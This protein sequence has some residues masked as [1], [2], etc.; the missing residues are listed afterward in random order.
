MRAAD[1]GDVEA[2]RLLIPL[3]K[4]IKDKYGNTAFVHARKSKHADVA[5]ILRDHEAPLSASFVRAA[6]AEGIEEA[7][8]HLSDEDMAEFSD[9]FNNDLHLGG[10]GHAPP[11][12]VR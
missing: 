10:L 5:R 6:A 9:I 11:P 7:G 1:R 3:Q 4:E 8:P 2:V 12:W